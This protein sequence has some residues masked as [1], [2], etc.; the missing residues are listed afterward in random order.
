MKK[1]A[2]EYSAF[3]V[4]FSSFLKYLII[5]LLTA[6]S[7]AEIVLAIMPYRYLKEEIYSPEWVF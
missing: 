3:I 2:V 5:T 4:M 1:L 6:K 7:K